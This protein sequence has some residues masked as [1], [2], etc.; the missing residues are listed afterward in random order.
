MQNK[1]YIIVSI[2]VLLGVFFGGGY[3]YKKSQSD[4]TIE[5][6][7]NDALILQRPY[8]VVLGKE[9]SK[10]QMVEFFDPACGTCA[11]F[12]HPVKSMLKDNYGDLKV[13][14]RYAPFH[15]NSDHAIKMLHG[16]NEQGKF[17][18]VLETMY[19]SQ[20]YWIKNHVVDPNILW[21]IIAQV[22]GLDMDKLLKF[23][24]SS[25]ADEIVKQDLADA[26]K[27]GVT[28]T[29]GFIVNGK[30][31][32]TFGLKNLQDLVESEINK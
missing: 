17:T 19:A 9:D 21:K 29:P 28:K 15:K 27:L 8:S 20:R 11:S 5:L 26:D 14:L 13:V 23:T 4:K 22:D 31:L 30:P 1:K 24:K 18:E 2:I 32:Q 3:L 12:Y 10:V 16:A 7:K 6:A 25:K